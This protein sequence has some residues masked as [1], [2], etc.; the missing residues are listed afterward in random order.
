[1]SYGAGIVKDEPTLH[2]LLLWAIQDDDY[3]GTQDYIL[4]N[5]TCLHG[6][7]LKHL[8]N[9]EAALTIRDNDHGLIKDTSKP[10]I[11]RRQKQVTFPPS[12]SYSSKPKWSIPPIPP[13]WEKGFGKAIFK[14]LNKWR[15]TA[16]GK[17]VSPTEVS[18]DFAVST[19][20]YTPCKNRRD[21]DQP[22]QRTARRANTTTQ[23]QAEEESNNDDTDL[24]PNKRMRIVLRKNNRIITDR[25]LNI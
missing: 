10:T 3:K 24:P 23:G 16:N 12:L 17:H 2:A 20:T 8:E 21:Q 18:T 15:D 22:R 6:D 14:L 13:S 19:T 9:R 4:G 25:P 7:I 5:P 1:M 11:L